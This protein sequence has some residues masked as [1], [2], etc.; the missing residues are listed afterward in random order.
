M[1]DGYLD[2]PVWNVSCQNGCAEAKDITSEEASTIDCLID[3]PCDEF[4]LMCDVDLHCWSPVS[5]G[6]DDDDL[7]WI[8]VQC[9]D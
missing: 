9:E 6:L 8:M 1:I 5:K 2:D 7:R 3:E 4:P